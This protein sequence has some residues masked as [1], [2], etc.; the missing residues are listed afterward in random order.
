M[1]VSP[2]T[3][4]KCNRFKDSLAITNSRLTP[5]EFIGKPMA[6]SGYIIPTAGNTT[7]PELIAPSDISR[8]AEFVKFLISEQQ[9]FPTTWRLMERVVRYEVLPIA[10]QRSAHMGRQPMV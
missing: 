5:H 7:K 6:K 2:R 8:P 3:Q 4:G 10:T 1:L 9:Y